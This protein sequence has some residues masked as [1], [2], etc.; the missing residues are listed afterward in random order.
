[1]SIGDREK[2]TQKQ[3]IRLFK[4][5]LGYTY[6]G[7]FTERNNSNIETEYLESFLKRQEY[8]D[9]LI[10]RAIRELANT[11]GNQQLNLYDLNK[12]VYALLRYGVKVKEKTGQHNVTVQFIDWE[13]PLKNDFYIAEE[14][15][16]VGKQIK[17]PDLVLY[18]NGIALGVIEL[19]RSTV[20]VAKGIRQNWTNQRPEFIMPFFATIGLV[21]AGNDSEGLKYGVTGTPEKYYLSWREDENALDEVSLSIRERNEKHPIKLDKN[22]ISLCSKERL[23]DI[24]HNFIVYD[25]GTKKT[26]RQNQYF[27]VKVAEAHVMR[28]EGGIIWHTQ[29]SGKSLTMVWLSKWIKEHIPESRILIVTDRDELDTQ[30]EQVYTGVDEKIIRTKSGQ[31]LVNKIND[32]SPALMCSLIHKFGRRGGTRTDDDYE[33]FIDEIKHS[34]PEGFSPKGDFYVFVDECHRTQSGKLHKAMNIILPHAVFIGFTGTPL[35]KKDKQTSFEI[36]GPFIHTYK[37]NEAV[38][39]KVILDL[40]YEAREVEQDVISQDKIDAWFEVKTRHLSETA[41]VQ[42]KMRWGTLKKV[43]SSKSRL[44]KIVADIIFDME[45]KGRLTGNG[46]GNAILVAGSIYHACKY[47]EIFQSQMFRK[48][49]IITSYNLNPGNI[50]TETV[51]DEGETEAAEQYDI[52]LK[53]LD[54]RDVETFEKEAKDKFINQPNQMKLLI[55][56]DK[57]LTGFDAPPATYLYIDKSMQDHGLFQAICR[58]NRLDSDDKEYGYIVDY[59]DLFRSLETAVKDYT[60]E[61][62]DSYDKEDVLNLLNDRLDKAK[63]QLENSLE[64]LCALC[65][66][67]ADPKDQIDY[68]H[69]F[70]GK[71]T[72]DVDSEELQENMPKR[73]QLYESAISALRAFSEV[74]YELQEKYGLS[75]AQVQAIDIEVS[76]YIKIR[77]YIRLASHD[78]IDLKAYDPDMRHLIDTYLSAK[79]STLLTSFGDMSLVELLVEH[80][81]DI[82]KDAPAETKK[83]QEAIAAVIENNIQKEIVERTQSNP[84]YY[85]A[86]SDLLKQ[87]IEDR[88]KAVLN[89]KH[90]LEK[91]V[92]L[93]KDIK[94]PETNTRYPESIK[95]SPGKRALYDNLDG[96]EDL[97]LEVH[98]AVVEYRLDSFRGN[99]IKER[100]IARA[101]E[102]VVHD[103]EKAQKLLDI[104]K[105]QNE[106]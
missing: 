74:S 72:D 16:Y 76:N 69:Y 59:K 94:N 92:S 99:Q 13:H 31:D 103:S 82:F 63:E 41:K 106:Y 49:A 93:A 42:L 39:D 79:P 1:M 9:V 105:K 66:D 58:V 30:I 24:L 27:G 75:S 29:G 17:R 70:C 4:E 97:A 37:F 51:G 38:R 71:D 78:Y 10:Q 52:Y 40:R 3:V 73:E 68:Y 5:E 14:V 18:V 53:M 25:G 90:Y 54:G 45:T 44:E 47:Y 23:L 95:D 65:E 12:S 43:F 100:K 85:A 88:K 6:R 2:Q 64:S 15:S 19:K 86:M 33:T 102:A 7:D 77:D 28:R 35:M 57:L 83:Q 36:F 50:R 48:C 89:Y 87:I 34:L 8:S 21:M 96:D 20:S 81:A 62:F 56:V 91:I 98:D 46:R 101:I 80:G 22:L 55:V 61:A 26:C 60:G 11:A 104:A 84:K 32:T 67:V